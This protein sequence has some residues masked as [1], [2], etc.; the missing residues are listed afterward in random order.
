[1]HALP[2]TFP[3]RVGEEA[4]QDFCIEIAL[5]L[6]ITVEPTG[7]KSRSRHNLLEETFSNP[8]RLNSLLA[9]SMIFLLT[10]ARCPE[11]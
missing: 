2:A 8:Y 9:L 11:G 3:I 4:S 5:A 10:L 7:S 1:M 6:E